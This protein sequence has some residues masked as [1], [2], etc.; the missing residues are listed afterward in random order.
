MQK[1]QHTHTHDKINLQNLKRT[2][3]ICRS[4]ILQQPD[5]AIEDEGSTFQRNRN[6]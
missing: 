3:S 6:M 5:K 2:C 1:W 4:Y